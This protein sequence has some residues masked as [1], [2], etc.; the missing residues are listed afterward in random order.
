MAEISAFLLTQGK[1]VL[2]TALTNRALIELASK[3]VLKDY[4]EDERL[5]KTNVTIDELHILPK[6]IDEKSV[7]CKPGALCL[8]TFYKTS[9]YASEIVEI[10]PFDYVIMD[11]A[12]QALLAMFAC[13]K[14]M[15]KHVVWIGDPYQ[16]PPV[17]ILEEEIIKRKGF[18]HLI[19]GFNTICRNLSVPSF[20]FTEV[21]D[22]HL[23]LQSS[24]VCSITLK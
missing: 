9:E 14:V 2:V 1:S 8:S 4:L 10:P 20:I 23:V 18:I 6:L 12:S 5:H 16:L 3:P 19:E 7:I 15:G 24:Q 13:S 21:I 11:E 17:T 22:L